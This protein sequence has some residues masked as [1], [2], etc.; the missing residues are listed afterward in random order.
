[1]TF[2][3]R[4]AYRW[5]VICLSHGR[6]FSWPRRKGEA[7]ESFEDKCPVR[8]FLVVH[9]TIIG[10]L[11]RASQCLCPNQL[12]KILARGPSGLGPLAEA[13]RRAA[14]PSAPQNEISAKAGAAED[15]R[16]GPVQAKLAA[17]EMTPLFTIH[18]N[19]LAISF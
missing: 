2:W 5:H 7:N 17:S 10:S 8:R 11:P 9:Q 19:P 12:A 13:H 14:L 15:G 3:D 4:L 18:S 1:M 6:G 16:D